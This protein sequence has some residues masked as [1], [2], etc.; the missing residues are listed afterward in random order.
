MITCCRIVGHV[1]AAI[2]PSLVEDKSHLKSTVI[3]VLDIYGTQ[4]AK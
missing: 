1:N 4:N 2:D 3:G